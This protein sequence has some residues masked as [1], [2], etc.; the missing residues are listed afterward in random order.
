MTDSSLRAH[1]EEYLSFR[2]GLGFDLGSAACHLRSFALYAE[3]VGHRVP[4][5]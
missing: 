2:R 4:S 3:Q 1:V 5:Q